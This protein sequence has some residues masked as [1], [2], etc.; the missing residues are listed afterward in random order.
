MQSAGSAKG[1]S[2]ITCH[3]LV[4]LERWRTAVQPAAVP[5]LTVG[6]PLAIMVNIRRRGSLRR[7]QLAT[8]LI[9]RPLA[10]QAP[11]HQTIAIVTTPIFPEG[12]RRTLREPPFGAWRHAR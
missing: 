5:V 9:L 3:S 10:Q 6:M 2:E 12:L 1:P 4:M 8:R 7:H 11:T